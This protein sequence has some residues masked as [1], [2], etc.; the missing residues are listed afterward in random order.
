M[1]GW[2]NY[3]ADS[4]TM[5]DDSDDGDEGGGDTI[6]LHKIKQDLQLKLKAE[7]KWKLT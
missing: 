1:T 3:W 7:K 5:L 6:E 4:L 2:K